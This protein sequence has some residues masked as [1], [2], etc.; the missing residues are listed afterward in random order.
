MCDLRTLVGREKVHAWFEEMWGSWEGR[1]PS[2]IGAPA[3]S[4]RPV[5]CA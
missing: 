4:S 3:T 2:E 1:A 5:P